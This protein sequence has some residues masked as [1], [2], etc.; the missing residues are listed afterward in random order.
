MNAINRL[1][2]FFNTT[3][4]QSS[5]YHDISRIILMNLTELESKSIYDVADMCYVSAP[6]IS[7]FCRKLDFKNYTDFRTQVSDLVRY[8]HF[9]SRHVPVTRITEGETEQTV[10]IKELQRLMAEFEAEAQR[11]LFSEIAGALNGASRVSIYP[12]GAQDTYVRLQTMLFFANIETVVPTTFS[13]QMDDA[14]SLEPGCFVIAEGQDYKEN[15]FRLPIVETAKKRGATIFVISSSYRSPFL[16][17]A[18]F[19]YCF[20]GVQAALDVH[21]IRMCVDF[22]SMAFRDAYLNI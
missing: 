3:N 9:M 21:R 4:G 11:T 7:K 13:T 15:L 16:N 10:Y 20:N 19:C 5:V 12:Y 18:D 1:V 22:I 8:H 2:E 14:S 6:T 17:F